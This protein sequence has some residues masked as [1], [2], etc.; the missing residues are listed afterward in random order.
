MQAEMLFHWLDGHMKRILIALFLTCAAVEAASAADTRETVFWPVG[1][2]P[3]SNIVSGP[4][5]GQ[6]SSDQRR[7]SLIKRMPEFRHEVIEV[8]TTRSID[9]LKSRPNVCQPNLL[10]TPEREEFLVFSARPFY[11]LPNGIITT[12]K[13]LP[14]FKPYLNEHGELRLADF[15]A[16]GTHRI[17]IISGRAFGAGI[18]PVLKKF[19]GQPSIVVVPSSDHLSSRL[20]KLANQN[21]FDA[22]IGYPYELR[23]LTRQLGFD[24][25]E[26]TLLPIAGVPVL[27][28]SFVA[29]SKSELGKRV[30]S[31]IDR[32][33]E[34]GSVQRESD[35]AYRVWLDDETA[36]R[37]DRLLK[38]SQRD[39]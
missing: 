25:R 1:D 30:M 5:K 37:F 2:F 35:V 34:D 15:L 38:Q 23:Y 31:A 8:P 20:L 16:D 10:K 27:T 13:R 32:A 12:R 24:E 39:K 18:D 29:C 7:H 36:A 6:G 19:A 22:V 26:F 4:Y 11:I 14:L 9:M 28:Q 17:G 33:L 3:P 21:E